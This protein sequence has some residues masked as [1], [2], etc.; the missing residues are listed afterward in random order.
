MGRNAAKLSRLLGDFAGTPEIFV[1]MA[2]E[3]LEG[4]DMA[5]LLGNLE[6]AIVRSG[7]YDD[8][9]FRERLFS[10][11][12]NEEI[13]QYSRE[14]VDIKN[15]AESI[16]G[17]PGDLRQGIDAARTVLGL[18]KLTREEAALFWKERIYRP[19]RE[20]LLRP[21]FFK[22]NVGF[23]KGAKR[24]EKI[25]FDYVSYGI[26]KYRA[27]VE[28]RLS[29][30][31]DKAPFWIWLNY[32]NAGEKGEYPSVSPT[33]F[34]ETSEVE[35]NIMLQAEITALA[36]EFTDAV[37]KE[38]ENFLR[39]PETYEPGSELALFEVGD[40]QFRLGVTQGGELSVR[41]TG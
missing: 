15:P 3:R 19:A 26:M 18:G 21:R 27:T 39:N 9:D 10:V 23:Y 16:A 29:A 41:R 37:G 31:G 1:A 33:M 12:S 32:G 17:N 35:I 13:I 14:G 2:V 40:I 24:G 36:D 11:F 30:W 38:V 5:I 8:P 4:H 7:E 28:A 20:G 6:T 25:P 22:K 34:V